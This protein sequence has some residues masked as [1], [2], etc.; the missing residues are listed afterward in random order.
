MTHVA[1]DDEARHE[2]YLWVDGIPLSRSKGYISRDFADGVLLAEVIHHFLPKLV[3]LHNYQSTTNS[4][5][6]R[7]NWET[8]QQKVLKRLQLKLSADE[9]DALISAKPGAI[10]RVLIRVR[11]A[12]MRVSA[13]SEEHPSRSDPRGDEHRLQRHLS[14]PSRSAPSVATASAAN[15]QHTPAP[16]PTLRVA[17]P[18]QPPPVSNTSIG[19]ADLHDGSS[20]ANGDLMEENTLLKQKIATLE[21]LLAV[22]NER[23]L[24]LERKIEHLEVKLKQ[25]NGA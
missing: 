3:E 20:I 17:P 19:L 23:I 1:L 11:S 6:K 24:A 12:I 9:I 14:A 15:Q 10:E 8:L 16:A 21:K 7:K 18:P 13:R 5:A 25:R 4:E 2:I 22:K